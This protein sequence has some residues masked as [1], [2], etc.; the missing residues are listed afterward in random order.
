[1]FRVLSKRL[2][3]TTS[4]LLESQFPPSLVHA[5]GLEKRELIA[6]L[7]GNNDP[8]FGGPHKFTSGT[9]DDPNIIRSAFKARIVGCIC[10]PEQFNIV[11]MWV[12]AEMPRRCGCGY[13]FKL[14]KVDPV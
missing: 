5:T 11:W 3:Q 4:G 1:M 7:E 9:R 8:Y 2:F 13:W 12:E 14:V 10:E 6:K